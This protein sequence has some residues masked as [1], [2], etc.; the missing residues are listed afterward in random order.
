VSPATLFEFDPPQTEPKALR[1]QLDQ[2][3]ANR[4]SGQLRQA[5][6]LL[7]VLFDQ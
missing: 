6:Q 7:T 1:K 4:E 3:L 5:H 2:L